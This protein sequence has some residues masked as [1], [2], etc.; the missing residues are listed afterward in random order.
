MLS[1]QTNMDFLR[2]V[3]VLKF[4]KSEINSENIISECKEREGEAP[5]KILLLLYTD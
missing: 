4:S 3:L 1:K 5:E 2:R